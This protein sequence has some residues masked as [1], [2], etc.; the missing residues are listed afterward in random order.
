ML[1]AS[2]ACLRSF[3]AL[4]VRVQAFVRSREKRTSTVLM[5]PVASTKNTCIRSYSIGSRNLCLWAIQ[6]PFPPGDHPLVDRHKS[7]PRKLRIGFSKAR[8][9]CEQRLFFH[10]W[11]FRTISTSLQRARLALTRSPTFPTTCS[12]RFVNAVE[13]L[14][15]C[16][17]SVPR[18][19]PALASSFKRFAI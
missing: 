8:C 4:F 11:S 2:A 3:S 14:R 17:A 16:A 7:M 6:R 9:K 18:R 19:R 10:G 5:L 12:M 15:N 13:S 1:R